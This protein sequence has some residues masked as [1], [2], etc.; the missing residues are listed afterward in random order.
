MPFTEPDMESQKNSVRVAVSGRHRLRT[1]LLLISLLPLI[2]LAE[3]IARLMLLP[4]FYDSFWDALTAE[5]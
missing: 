2:R 1:T 3:A 4:S 5:M